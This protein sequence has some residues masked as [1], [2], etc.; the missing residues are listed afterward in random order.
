MLPLDIRSENNNEPQ[1]R[2]RSKNDHMAQNSK[3]V[4]I[5]YE[6]FLLCGQVVGGVTDSRTKHLMTKFSEKA[7]GEMLVCGDEGLPTHRGWGPL[8]WELAWQVSLESPSSL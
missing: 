2:S 6:W 4:F 8:H 7:L 3:R 5:R 1:K